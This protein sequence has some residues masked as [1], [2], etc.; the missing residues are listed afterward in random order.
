MQRK[1][2]AEKIGKLNLKIAKANK[3]LEEL[4]LQY[5]KKRLELRKYKN[6]QTGLQLQLQELELE[7]SKEIQEQKKIRQIQKET[8]KK[9]ADYNNEYYSQEKTITIQKNHIKVM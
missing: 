5:K 1:D 8:I 4:E 2:I 9:Y 3:E 7:N 6:K